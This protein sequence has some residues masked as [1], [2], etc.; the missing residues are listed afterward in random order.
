V[1]DAFVY[2]YFQMWNSTRARIC[3]EEIYLP[4]E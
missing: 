2:L 4:A 3:F 1:I